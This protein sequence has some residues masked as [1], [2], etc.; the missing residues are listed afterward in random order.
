MK[1]IMHILSWKSNN[2]ESDA[3]IFLSRIISVCLH[4]SEARPEAKKCYFCTQGFLHLP[5]MSIGNKFI[6]WK[7]KIK[8]IFIADSVHKSTN[9]KNGYD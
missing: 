5:K 9:D 4:P 8:L 3:D 2:Q 7:A 1:R 6:P